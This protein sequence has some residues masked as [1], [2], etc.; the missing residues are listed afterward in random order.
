MPVLCGLVAAAALLTATSQASQ[1][2]GGS[3]I[4]LRNEIVVEAPWALTSLQLKPYLWD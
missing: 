4:R 2:A 1:D 3:Y